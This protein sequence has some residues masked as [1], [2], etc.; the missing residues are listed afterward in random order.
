MLPFSDP[1]LNLFVYRHTTVLPIGCLL[2]PIP[3]WNSKYSYSWSASSFP[4]IIVDPPGKGVGVFRSFY[5]NVCLWMYVR[6]SIHLLCTLAELGKLQN[7]WHW[8]HKQ[9][10]INYSTYRLQISVYN[11]SWKNEII[12]CW[13]SQQLL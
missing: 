5:C 10:H 7:L 9:F 4:I 13:P 12:D 1:I 11:I 2:V 8:Q 3:T 6:I